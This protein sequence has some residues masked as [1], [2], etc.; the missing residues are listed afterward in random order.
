MVL[1]PLRAS[2]ALP[3]DAGC[4][5]SQ[6]GA[7]RHRPVPSFD[8][9]NL[10]RPPATAPWS[11]IKVAEGCDRNCGFCAIPSF[12]GKQRSRSPESIL[13]EVEQLGGP[14]GGLARWCWWPRTCRRSPSTG[15]AG[16]TEPRIDGPAVGASGPSSTWSPRCR[17]GCGGPGSSISIRRP[18]TT[19]WSRPSWPPGCPTSTFRS[20]TCRD[21]C[22]SACADGARVTRF[23]ERI[24]SIRAARADGRVPVVVHRR[25]P[26]RDRGRPRPPAG[27]GS[28]RP[29]STGWASSPSATRPA[30]TPPI[31]TTRCP[32]GWW[33]SG[34]ASAPSSRT[35]SPPAGG[36][37]LIGATVEVLVDG[38]GE[39][40]TYREAPEIDGI[41]HLPGDLP[42]GDVRR[43]GGDRSRRP[44]PAGRAGG[45][46]RGPPPL[47]DRGGVV[48]TGA[49]G[50]G[51]PGPRQRSGG[52]GPPPSA[53]RPCSPR[54]TGSPCSGC[55]PPRW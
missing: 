11:Y 1:R 31:S 39:G 6:A 16:R 18:S 55:W 44:R 41:V 24:G 52:D 22:S 29:S 35:P 5:G 43:R 14:A 3:S 7:V 21:R 10:P 9:L 34:S 48:S 40:R 30:P 2:A 23:L 19:P 37:E 38:P 47:L 20:S 26:G 50:P 45:R 46:A 17:R 27:S 32:T 8:L 42:V 36:E 51:S 54:P 33:P 12:R 4:H 13:A 49:I 25:L 28:T 53:P 15:R